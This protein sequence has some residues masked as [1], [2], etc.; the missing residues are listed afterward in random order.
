MTVRGSRFSVR[1]IVIALESGCENLKALEVAADMAARTKAELHGVFVE[2]IQLLR[3]AALPFARQVSLH[4]IESRPLETV[5]VEAELRALAGRAR[6][7]LQ[8]LATQMNVPWSFETV[9]GDRSAIVSATEVT[10]MLVVETTTRPFARHMR[11]STDWSDIAVTCE[12][13][14]LLLAAATGG[15]KG[16]LTVYDGSESGARAIAAAAAL[17]GEHEGSLTIASLTADGDLQQRLQTAG[18]QPAIRIIAGAGTSELTRIIAEAN[19]DLVIL[20]VS[21]VAARRAELEGLLNAPPCA[22]LLIK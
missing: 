6:R 19:C 22:L 3:L 4:A 17:G 11:L 12:R 20:P 21:F 1:R 14:C 8:D 9:R 16:I 13:A 2:D 5:D 7:C 18:L 10:D 15:R